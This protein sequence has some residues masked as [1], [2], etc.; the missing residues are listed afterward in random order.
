MNKYNSMEGFF[1][2]LMLTALFFMSMNVHAGVAST[3][4]QEMRHQ[5]LLNP[6]TKNLLEANSTVS[7]GQVN[8]SLPAAKKRLAAMLDM[9]NE[10]PVTVLRMSFSAAVRKGFPTETQN[11]L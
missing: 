9:V 2:S 1:I 4:N 3:S 10:D 6:L 5:Q 7:Q 8:L 11:F